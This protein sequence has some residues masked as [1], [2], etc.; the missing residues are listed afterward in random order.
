MYGLTPARG[1]FKPWALLRMPGN[2]WAFRFVYPTLAVAAVDR[3]YI[4]DIPTAQLTLTIIDPEIQE[5][6]E[7][8][9]YI[10]ISDRFIFVSRWDQIHIISRETGRNVLTINAE[11]SMVGTL[12]TFEPTQPLAIPRDV[13]L[14]SQDEFLFATHPEPF[15]HEFIAGT[16]FPYIHPNHA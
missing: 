13:E 14:I 2:T 7:T 9:N 11:L 1:R 8:L 15:G 12:M 3:Y 5:D 4:W 6:D 10:E 16:S